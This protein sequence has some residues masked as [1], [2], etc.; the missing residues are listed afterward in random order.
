MELLHA[1]ANLCMPADV[2]LAR[3]ERMVALLIDGLRY[4]AKPRLQSAEP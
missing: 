3:A 4:G 1:V 2:D